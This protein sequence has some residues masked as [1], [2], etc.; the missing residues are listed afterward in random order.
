MKTGIDAENL[1]LSWINDLHGTAWQGRAVVAGV[2]LSELLRRVPK[3]KRGEVLG[4]ILA[5]LVDDFPQEMH[6]VSSSIIETALLGAIEHQG[7]A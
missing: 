5:Q 7:S 2:F 6:A 3:Q 1:I 4:H